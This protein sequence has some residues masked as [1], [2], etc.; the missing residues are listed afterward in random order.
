M[1]LLQKLLTALVGFVFTL[2]GFG[3]VSAR[4]TAPSTSGTAVIAREN[5]GPSSGDK[6]GRESAHF[7]WRRPKITKTTTIIITNRKNRK[8]PKKTRNR[9]KPRKPKKPRQKRK[10]PKK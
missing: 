10:S 7:C 6:L 8:N 5:R 9:K 3:K 1:G 2:G 4:E